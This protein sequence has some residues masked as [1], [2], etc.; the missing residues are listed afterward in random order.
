MFDRQFSNFKDEKIIQ[1]QV[2]NENDNYPKFLENSYSFEIQENESPGYLIGE[3]EAKDDDIGEFGFIT[4]S[5][6]SE[7]IKINSTTG[8]LVLSQNVDRE[9]QDTDHHF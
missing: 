3:I 4:Y 6:E 5:I 8:K 1:I 2:L 7:I 9:L